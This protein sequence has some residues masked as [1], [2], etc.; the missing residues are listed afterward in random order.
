MAIQRKVQRD[1]LRSH[2]GEPAIFSGGF[3]KHFKD[4]QNNEP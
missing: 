4:I 1:T 2:F 3:K